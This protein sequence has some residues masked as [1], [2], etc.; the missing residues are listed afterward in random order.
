MNEYIVDIDEVNMDID[1]QR[2]TIAGILCDVSPTYETLPVGTTYT[3]VSHKTPVQLIRCRDCEHRWQKGWKLDEFS[4][5]AERDFCSLCMDHDY[6][7]D[8]TTFY[9]VEPD[10]YCSRAKP[11]KE[12]TA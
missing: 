9:Y 1:M 2:C 7:Y 8:Y 5:A 3:I 11:R 4:N 10:D 6:D 12:G